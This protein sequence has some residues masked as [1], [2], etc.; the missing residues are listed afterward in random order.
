[1]WNNIMTVRL[2]AISMEICLFNEQ[3]DSAALKF[4][5][6]EMFHGIHEHS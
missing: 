3:R 1:M 2:N 5:M 4:F 6:Q